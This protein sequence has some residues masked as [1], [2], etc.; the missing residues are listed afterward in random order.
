MALAE[1]LAEGG[2]RPAAE[3][4]ARD[5]RWGQHR[6]AG[7]SAPAQG[8][9]CAGSPLLLLPSPPVLPGSPGSRC[10]CCCCRDAPLVWAQDGCSGT[11]V[12]VSKAPASPGRKKPW[13]TSRTVQ[14]S[15]VQL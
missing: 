13:K 2:W 12:P 15:F 8:G 5:G 4:W 11:R 14:R 3:G 6:C 1:P 7:A 9:G 10:C